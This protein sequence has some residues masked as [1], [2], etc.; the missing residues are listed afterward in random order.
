M[1]GSKFTPEQ[2]QGPHVGPPG[3]QHGP[4]FINPSSDVSKNITASFA[5][6]FLLFFRDFI[7]LKS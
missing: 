2:G 1:Q 3:F 7:L 5:S 6:F 4:P